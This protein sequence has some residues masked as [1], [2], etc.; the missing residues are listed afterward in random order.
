[1]KCANFGVQDEQGNFVGQF[2][3][4]EVAAKARPGDSGSPVFKGSS[5]VTLVGLLWGT[6]FNA[7][8][9]QIRYI[10]SP[11]SGIEHDLGALT[12]F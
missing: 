6:E 8:N 3:Q 1:M 7:N 9:V 5:S 12:T 10:Y 4:N 11:M 2:C